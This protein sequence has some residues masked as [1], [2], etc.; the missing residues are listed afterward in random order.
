MLSLGSFSASDLKWASHDCRNFIDENSKYWM[1]SAADSLESSVMDVV[2]FTTLLSDT[3]ADP[4]NLF[5]IAFD[6]RGIC[7]SVVGKGKIITYNLNGTIL[8]TDGDHSNDSSPDRGTLGDGSCLYGDGHH[9]CGKNKAGM[10]FSNGGSDNCLSKADTIFWAWVD[11]THYCNQGLIIGTGC[12]RVGDT[13]ELKNTP[14]L[15]TFRFNF[16]WSF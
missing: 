12:E 15:P 7:S 3:A 2:R 9:F 6:D 11:D 10:R 4:T 1:H 13:S 8:T 16:L 14:G 5:D